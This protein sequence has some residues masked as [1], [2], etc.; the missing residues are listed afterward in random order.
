ME[1]F[2]RILKKMSK[3]REF[4]FYYRCSSLGISHLIFADDVML[5]YKG[6]VPSSLLM[7]RAFQAFTEA[8]GLAVS[9]EKSIIYFGNVKVGIQERILQVTGFQR[10]RFP[11][12]YLGVPITSKRLLKVDCDLIVDRMLKRILC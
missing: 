10:G 9:H 11:L 3:K 6:D 1:Y 2:T 12:R 7:R 4:S 5:F 8:F